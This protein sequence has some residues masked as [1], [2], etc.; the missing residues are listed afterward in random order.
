M[1][2][3]QGVG[4]VVHNYLI[5]L[6][7]WAY[8]LSASLSNNNQPTDVFVKWEAHFQALLSYTLCVC[9]QY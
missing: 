9:G 5:I 2:S 1:Y 4:R 6:T 3:G 8:R 7:T